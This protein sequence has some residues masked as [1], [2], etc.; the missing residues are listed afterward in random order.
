MSATF[1]GC[2]LTVPVNH[3][4]QDNTPKPSGHSYEGDYTAGIVTHV[5]CEI[6]VGLVAA[7]T[8]D[9]PWIYNWGTTV[10]QSITVE[11]QSGASPG[12]TVLSPIQNVVKMF[13]AG[14][15]VILPQTASESIGLSGSFNALRTETIQYT[16]K[17]RE[18]I[19][20]YKP[21][22]CDKNDILING[23]LKIKDFIYDNATVARGGHILF[24]LSGKT[25]WHKPVFNVF[26][27]EITFVAAFGGTFTPTWKLARIQANAASNLLLAERT[28]TN[29]LVITLG[30]LDP[31]TPVNSPVQLTQAAQSQHLTRVQASA[32]AVSLQGQSH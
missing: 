30:P 6:S 29:D 27:E 25:P 13:P 10:T 18:I 23:N 2:G 22:P 32:I 19:E 8:L 31:K 9:L 17:N 24:A 4:L 21:E 11:D 14:G 3:P 16:F 1:G 15:N 7:N 5:L 12:L 28:T 26:S 20:S